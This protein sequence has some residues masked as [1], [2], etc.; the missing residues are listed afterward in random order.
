MAKA[1]KEEVTKC[2]KQF[3]DWAKQEMER[4]GLSRAD[5][6]RATLIHPANIRK[7]FDP[8]S[9]WP[10]SLGSMSRICEALGY[11]LNLSFIPNETDGQS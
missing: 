2:Q 1:K 4:Q 9:V 7:L 3:R 8:K 6:A 5:L 10:P 11:T